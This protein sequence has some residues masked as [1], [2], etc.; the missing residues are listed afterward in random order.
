MSA[1]ADA[2]P[3]PIPAEH[4]KPAKKR[5]SRNTVRALAWAGGIASFALPWAAFQALPKPTV[6]AAPQVVVVPAGS[7]VT[8]TKGAAGVGSGVKIVTTKGS[9]SSGAPV[10]STHGSVPPP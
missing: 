4:G 9:S 8:V 3:S 5:M 6:A 2:G 10:T 7:K 1:R